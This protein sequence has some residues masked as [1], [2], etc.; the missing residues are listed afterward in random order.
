MKGNP[1]M[2]KPICQGETE[3]PYTVLDKHDGWIYGGSRPLDNPQLQIKG[4]GES[5]VAGMA[6]SPRCLPPAF[7]NEKVEVSLRREGD[8][9]HQKFVPKIVVRLGRLCEPP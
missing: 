8:E 5:K 1:V 7:L 4:V 9:K 2:G 6:T 3:I